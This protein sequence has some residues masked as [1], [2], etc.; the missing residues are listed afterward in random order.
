MMFLW[1]PFLLL[2]PFAII[3]MVRSGADGGCCGMS[4]TSSAQ[5]HGQNSADPMDIAAERLARGEITTAEFDEI[6]KA[7]G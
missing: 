3:W 5:T 4:H 1:L 2:I 6:R 7:I